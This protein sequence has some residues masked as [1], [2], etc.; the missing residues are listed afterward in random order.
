MTI[1]RRAVLGGA[2]AATHLR[3]QVTVRPNVLVI[4]FD[5]LGVQDL[6]YLGAGDLKTPNIDKLAVGGT[7]CRN[8]YSNAPVCAPGLG[9]MVRRC[10]RERG[11]WRRF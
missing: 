4:L 7:L 5:D 10:R 11:A 3:G 6:G 1:S 2:V 8:W 9:I